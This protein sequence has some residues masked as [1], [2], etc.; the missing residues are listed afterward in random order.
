MVTR[1]QL[2]ADGCSPGAVRHLVASAAL[3]RQVRGVYLV[4]GAPWTEAAR[5]WTAVL[6]TG[7]VLGFATGAHL[8][9]MAEPAPDIDVIVAPG[10]RVAIPYG[11]RMHRV[12][13]RT[14]RCTSS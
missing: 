2:M 12:S 1:A 5:L 10:R 14:G 8:W 11:V 6:A 13:P 7:G 9:G 4:R 3:E